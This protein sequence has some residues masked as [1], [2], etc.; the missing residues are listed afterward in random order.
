MNR[1]YRYLKRKDYYSLEI[2]YLCRKARV[3]EEYVRELAD[4]SNLLSEEFYG[5]YQDVINI[6]TFNN[7]IYVG[8]ETRRLDYIEDEKKGCNWVA[9][10]IKKGHYD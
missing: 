3:T 10:A 2:G 6:F 1:V 7:V 5:K 9:D 4:P 8:L